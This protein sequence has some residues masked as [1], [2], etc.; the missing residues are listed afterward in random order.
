MVLPKALPSQRRKGQG[1]RCKGMQSAF[2][3]PP[4]PP[5][6]C[7]PQAANLSQALTREVLSHMAVPDWCQLC[8]AF[9]RYIA[10]KGQLLWREGKRERNA[11][12]PAGMKKYD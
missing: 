11:S 12:L 6:R 2:A 4:P 8:G 5:P 9:P 3:P 10:M 7:H 1:R